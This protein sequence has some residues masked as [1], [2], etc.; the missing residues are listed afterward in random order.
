MSNFFD[1]IRL[2]G[3]PNFQPVEQESDD[4]I[5]KIAKAD[6]KDKEMRAA[7]MHWA[8]HSFPDGEVSSDD[9]LINRAQRIYA[10]L[11]GSDA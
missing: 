2:Y 8:M 3:G 1:Q 5:A 11:K 7:A 4:P 9:Q 10:F 6:Q